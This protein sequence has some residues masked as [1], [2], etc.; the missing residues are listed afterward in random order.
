MFVSPLF[1]LNRV[2]LTKALIV[3][4]MNKEFK[5]QLINALK[6]HY[7]SKGYYGDTLTIAERIVSSGVIE[8]TW[9]TGGISGGNCWGGEARYPVDAEEEPDL[10]ELDYIL[11]KLASSVTFLQYK[12]IV[13]KTVTKEDGGSN[14]DYYG[15]YTNSSKKILNL[16]NLYKE[17]VALNYVN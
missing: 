11:E 17:L 1:L 12:I 8:A 15:N 16:E 13:R 5:E 7:D 10:E 9:T 14:S 4:T 3:L 6:E 2:F